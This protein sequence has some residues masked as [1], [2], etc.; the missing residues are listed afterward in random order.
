MSREGNG[1][2][3]GSGTSDPGGAAKG[4]GSVCSGG[5]EA[6]GELSHSPELLTGG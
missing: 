3:K 4:A 6:Q 1:A 5:K 2:G